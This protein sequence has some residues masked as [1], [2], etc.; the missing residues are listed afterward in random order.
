MRTVAAV[1]VLAGVGFLAG[2]ALADPVPLPP[3]TTLSVPVPSVPSSPVPLPTIPKLPPPVL[4]AAPEVTSSTSTAEAAVSPSSISPSSIP[5]SSTGSTSSQSQQ[6]SSS[7]SSGSR[8]SQPRSSRVE[9]FNSSRHWIATNGPKRRRTTVLTFVLPRAG[10]VVFFVNELSPVCRGVGRFTIAGH[11]GL[12]RVRFTGRVRGR[13]LG[14]GTYRISAR[15]AAGRVVRRVTLVVVEAGA[16]SRAELM[17][18]RASNVCAGSRGT[19]FAAGSSTGAQAIAQVRRSFTPQEHPSA[20]GAPTGSNSHSGAVLA[21][22]IE[23]TARAIQPFLVALLATAIVLLGLASLPRAAVP[24]PRLNETLARHRLE[25]AGI[26]AV[27][28]V[29]VAVAFLLG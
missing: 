17:A 10:R 14:P 4:P 18:A 13:Q 2:H 9:H 20:A 12:N 22:S 19:A 24:D 11:A 6:G 15:T 21:S 27:A 23:K 16:P 28:L 1:V 7:G 8:A 3:I 5:G 29:G 25:I 26:G